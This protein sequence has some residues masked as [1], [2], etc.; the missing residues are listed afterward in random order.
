MGCILFQKI[1]P[2][3]LS[4]F[5][6]LCSFDENGQARNQVELLFTS[7]QAFDICE[8]ECTKAEGECTRGEGTMFWKEMQ[9]KREEQD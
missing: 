3:L 4:S 8:G 9:P 2:S 1:A 7:T 5:T 6:F